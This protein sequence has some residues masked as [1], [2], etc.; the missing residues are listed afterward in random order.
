MSNIRFAAALARLTD[1]DPD[2]IACDLVAACIAVRSHPV[3]NTSQ[4]MRDDPAVRLLAYRLAMVCRVRV[5]DVPEYDRL[6]DS[7]VNKAGG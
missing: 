2:A 5:P 3:F 6:V 4:A 7:C 1:F